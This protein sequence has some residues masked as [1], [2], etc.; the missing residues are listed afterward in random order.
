M[1]IVLFYLT[2]GLLGA[3]AFL[4]AAAAL[5]GPIHYKKTGAAGARLREHVHEDLELIG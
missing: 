5:S 3:P 4:G 1:N 2:S